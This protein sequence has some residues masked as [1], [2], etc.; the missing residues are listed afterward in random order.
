MPDGVIVAE[1]LTKFYGKT[2][3]VEDLDFEVKPG[4][5][6]GYL[7]PNGAGKTTTIRTMLDFMRPTRGRIRVLGMDSK[8]RSIDIHRRVGYLPSELAL[9]PSMT[10]HEHLEYFANL[11]GGVDER[12]IQALAERVGCDLTV[13]IKSLSH[14]NRQKVG[15]IQAF[16]HRPDLFVLDEPSQGLDPLVQQEFY[17]LVAE[18][19]EEGRT[20]FISSHVMPEVERLCDRVA[21]IREG[22]LITVED[23][24][25]MKARS[26]RTIGFHFAAPVPAAEFERLPNVREVQVLGDTLRC[27]VTGPMDALIKL[28][29]RFDVVNV[30][31]AEASL[32]DIFLAF[33]GKGENYAG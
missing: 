22:K 11:R 1:G 21:I 27:S 3:G 18:A 16:M 17:A 5:V 14:G 28:A 19:R 6:F 10:G 24:G 25:D 13:R 26:L 8:E 12:A 9:Y 33:Y 30:Q 7:G 20:V 29:A 23:V 4:E 32:E 15:L 2:R 31:T